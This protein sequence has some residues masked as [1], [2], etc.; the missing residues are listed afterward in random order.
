MPQNSEISKDLQYWKFCLYGFLKNLRFFDPFLILYFREMGLSFLQIGTLI[1]I[2]EIA[3]NLLEIP[4]GFFADSFG[5][6]GSMILAFISYIC[7]FAVFAFLPSFGFHAIAM[8]LFALGEAYRTGTHKAMILENLRLTNQEGLKIDYY[9][10][11]RSWS[12]RG[13]ALSSV[14]AAVLV[15]VSTGYRIV[16]AASIIPYVLG[17]ILMM[18]YPKRLNGQIEVSK[19]ERTLGD[20]FRQASAT[21]REGVAMIKDIRFLRLLMNSAGFEAMFRSVKD[22]IQPVLKEAAVALPLLLALANEQRIAIVIGIVYFVLYFLTSFASAS[23]GKL[24]KGSYSL[25]KIINVTLIAGGLIVVAIGTTHA[26]WLPSAAIFPFVLLYLLYNFR[27]PFTVGYVSELVS[28]RVMASGLSI[29]SQLKTILSAL[30]APL[31]GFIA[32]RAGIGWALC[33]IGLLLLA[34][35]PLLAIKDKPVASVKDQ[36]E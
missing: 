6:R 36:V 28:S 13:S 35:Y 3:T 25:P 19:G 21:W 27:K 8:I 1:S 15:V 12:Q 23:A 31:M 14:I 34:P 33:A 29:Q 10:H 2:R 11:T 18:T 32:D 7:S 20:L 17:L 4:T 22:Y 30:A 26:F 9:G 5:R 16:F 24:G